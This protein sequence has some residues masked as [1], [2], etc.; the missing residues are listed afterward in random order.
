MP[1][2]TYE[3]CTCRGAVDEF[4]DAKVVEHNVP[5]DY[6]D[7]VTCGHCDKPLSRKISFTGLTW[8]PTAGG[9]R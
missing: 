2:Y 1:T 5:I 6:R 8:A 3:T 7:E 4:G 9:M